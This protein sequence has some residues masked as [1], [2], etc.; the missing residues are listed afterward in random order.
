MTKI[1]AF[2]G[3]YVGTAEGDHGVFT[4]KGTVYAG[5]IAGDFARVGVVTGTNGDTV[6]VECDADGKEHGR[7]LGCT[8]GGDTVYR[9]CEH[10]SEKE[11][12]V[13]RADGTRTYNGEACRAD[14]APFVALKAMVVPIKARPA[15]VP[16]TAASLYAAFFSP[17]PPASRSHRPLF[18]HS[19]ELATTHADKVRTCRLRHQPAWALWRSNCQ[20]NAPRVQPGRH[21]GGRVLYACGTT[22]CV[23]HPS[24][25][26]C[27]RS[28]APCA[29]ALPITCRTPSGSV[30]VCGGLHV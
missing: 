19:Q 21:T 20:T 16:P 18:S 22:A 24:A 7:W 26:P 29:S 12:A 25:V 13:L 1:N 28:E 9:R 27:P 15:P 4:S 6:F 14:Y 2:G 17:P 10:G 8:A 5:Q 30:A 3:T 23:V 11:W